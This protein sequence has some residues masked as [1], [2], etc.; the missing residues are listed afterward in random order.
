MKTNRLI[1][2]PLSL[3][4][5]QA[6]GGDAPS[7]PSNKAAPAPSAGSSERMTCADYLPEVRAAILGHLRGTER[8]GL[9]GMVTGVSASTYASASDQGPVE[10]SQSTCSFFGKKLR[11]DRKPDTDAAFKLAPAC[12]ARIERIDTDC[13]KPL[14][15]RG[16]PL[17]SVC[18]STLIGMSAGREDLAQMLADD[19]YCTDT[20]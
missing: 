17:N 19:G 12:A 3:L 4:L 13:L 1:L 11:K 9:I 5:L 14:A 20:Q 7:A 10:I 8:I 6:C 16:V 18:N 2:L 15:E